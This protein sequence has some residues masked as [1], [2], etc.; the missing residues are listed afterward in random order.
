MIATY[1]SEPRLFFNFAAEEAVVCD[2][3]ECFLLALCVKYDQT[4]KLR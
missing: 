2:T 3:T 4:L 1:K